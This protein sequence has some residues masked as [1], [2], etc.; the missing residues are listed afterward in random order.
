MLFWNCDFKL[1]WCLYLILGGGGGRGEKQV[2]F[3]V[4]RLFRVHWR[5]IFSQG[6]AWMRPHTNLVTSSQAI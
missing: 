4:E 6:V 1:S 3:V 2:I 5:A